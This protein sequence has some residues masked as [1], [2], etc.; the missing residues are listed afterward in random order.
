[1]RSNVRACQSLRKLHPQAS[2]DTPD[3]MPSSQFM[4]PVPGT[5]EAWE[6]TCLCETV[7]HSKGLET[8][9]ERS[10]P[11]LGHSQ[12]VSKT[13][14]LDIS[15]TKLGASTERGRLGVQ[16]GMRQGPG[17]SLVLST[18]A[19]PVRLPLCPSP[20]PPGAEDTPT[21]LSPLGW[22]PGG[23]QAW[24]FPVCEEGRSP[25][26][27]QMEKAGDGFPGATHLSGL[28]FHIVQ[29]AELGTCHRVAPHSPSA[30]IPFLGCRIF[31]PINTCW[32]CDCGL[33]LMASQGGGLISTCKRQQDSDVSLSCRETFP[34]IAQSDWHLV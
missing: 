13:T 7:R 18:S 25:S 23:F 5:E 8:W 21:S 15:G 16:K 30:D 20:T 31:S 9:S 28:S 33:A 10:R 24:H 26:R 29:A 1:M 14:T 2:E 11:Q 34:A 22:C 17:Y 4:F 27:L 32:R 19:P 3:W 12:E 6:Q